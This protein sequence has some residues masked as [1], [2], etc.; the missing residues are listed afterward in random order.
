M[1]ILYV[2][3]TVQ[4]PPTDLQTDRFYL[5]SENLEG[6]VLQPIW[7]QTPEHV[8]ARFGPGSYPVYTVGR[9]RY[10]WFLTPAVRGI[11]KRLATFR[12]YIQKGFA[13]HRERPFD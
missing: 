2:H 5:L 6:D 11:G 12:F 7:F 4:P 13:L 10:H 9:F 3:S 8:E 1:R